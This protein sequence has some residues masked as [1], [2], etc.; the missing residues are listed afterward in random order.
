M[1]GIL[2][3]ARQKQRR[4]ALIVIIAASI[5]SAL[6]VVNQ[7]VAALLVPLVVALAVEIV[8]RDA[9]ARVL[10]QLIVT[11]QPSEKL[12]VPR[13][14]WGELSRAINNLVQQRRLQQRLQSAAP[15]GL[16]D[17]AVQAILSGELY[18]AN[19]PRVVSVLLIRAT[20]QRAE[21]RAQ[22]AA[23]QAW[24]KL[25]ATAHEHAQQHGALLQP[26]G[27]ALMLVFGAFSDQSADVTAR[28][29]LSVGAALQCAW[30]A[31]SAGRE[32]T[33]ALSIAT[34]SAWIA[35]LPGLGCSVV[36][37]PVQQASHILHLSHEAHYD[38]P[39]CNEE[40]YYALRSRSRANWQP[41]PLRLHVQNRSPQPV[42]CWREAA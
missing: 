22:R 17:A 12:E 10:A 41:T 35:V 11:G 36:G 26:Y 33:L 29:A 19:E 15:A 16:P 13:G 6:I 21:Q 42:Y 9:R 34:G 30:R 7:P 39:L 2:E 31:H 14:A 18:G 8:W 24:Q 3:A 32:G 38:G 40:V 4:L 27:D 5:S 28:A 37:A 1:N 20:R 23:V 25:A